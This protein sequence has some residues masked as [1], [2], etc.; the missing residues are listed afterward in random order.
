MLPSA[1][2]LADYAGTVEV[3]DRVEVHA[4]E[5]QGA[6]KN[7]AFDVV[8]L[9][10]LRARITDRRWEYAAAYT[11]SFTAPDL[12]LGWN[13]QL[14]HAG[15]LGVGWHDR[16]V[17]LTLTES[18]SYGV[19]NTAFLAAVQPAMG[20]LPVTTPTLTQP[21][22]IDIGSSR[23]FLASDLEL[24]RVTTFGAD[25]GYTIQG[26]LDAAA[27]AVLPLLQGPRADAHLLVKATRVDTF[28]TDALVQ[29]SDA[30]SGPCSALIPGVTAAD[31]CQV[32]SYIGQT[33]ESWRRRLAP[34][35]TISLGAGLAVARTR[36]R[37][38]DTFATYVYPVALASYE[39]ETRLVAS[40]LELSPDTGSAHAVLRVDAQIAPYIDVLTGAEDYRA[41]GTIS[42]TVPFYRTT[43]RVAMWS[44]KSIE[45]QFIAPVTMY[46][47]DVDLDH[48]LSDVLSVGIGAR[49]AWQD[50]APFGVLQTGILLAQATVRAPIFHF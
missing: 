43:V 25:V 24:S 5:T 36:I 38:S 46:R 41:Q 23:T 37:S 32:E 12:E 18:A 19:Q 21:A 48:R 20:T 16:R 28:V 22:S 26:G 42:L 45:S 4:R 27:Q 14:L 13:P 6:Q 8:D 2:L 33:S 1:L 17:R 39:H 29:R 9:A 3:A 40:A 30:E 44:M 15:M 31:E 10:T 47:V 34:H 7:P 35:D 50:Q 49:Y 11:P